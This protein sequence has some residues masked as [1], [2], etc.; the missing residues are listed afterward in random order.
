YKGTGDSEQ[1]RGQQ[2]HWVSTRNEKPG[3]GTHDQSD[4]Q[5]PENGKHRSPPFKSPDH[6]SYTQNA[7]GSARG[8]WLRG[9]GPTRGEERRG[10]AQKGLGEGATG[11]E[12]QCEFPIL[13]SPPHRVPASLFSAS[14]LR[15]FASSPHPRP[16][17]SDCGTLL[18]SSWAF[19]K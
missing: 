6:C 18:V 2:T 1:N 17:V 8:E 14:P 5:P 13:S 12:R 9:E 7:N 16:S 11:E 15:P 19:I 4:N 3:E 10:D